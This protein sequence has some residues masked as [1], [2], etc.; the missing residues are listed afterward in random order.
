M[1][2]FHELK[3]YCTNLINL[4]EIEEESEEGRLFRPNYIS[5]CRVL[6]AYNIRKLLQKIKDICLE[7]IKN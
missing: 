6:D 5:S 3:K 4:L 7:D 1:N 2:D